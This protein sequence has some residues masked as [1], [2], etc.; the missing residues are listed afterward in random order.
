MKGIQM[1]TDLNGTPL[2]A[3][4][5]MPIYERMAVCDLP[6]FI[7]PSRNCF[8][9]DYPGE[10][11]SRYNLFSIIGWPHSTSM[12]M[13]RLAYGGVLEKFPSLKII[14]HHA[15]GT[16]PYLAKRIEL[17]DRRQLPAHRR[18][19]AA[20]LRGYGRAGQHSQPDV[21]PCVLWRR[22]SAFRYRLSLQPRHVDSRTGSRRNGHSG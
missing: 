9:P 14:T 10:A 19:P 3:P 18:L 6:I 11:E 1:G 7:H 20:F 21:R 15:G 8:A 5:L 13:M 12:A 16:I 17:S 4:E 22:S 2:D